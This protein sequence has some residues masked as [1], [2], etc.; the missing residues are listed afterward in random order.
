MFDPIEGCHLGLKELASEDRRGWSAAARADRVRGLARLAERTQAVLLRAVVDWDA[1]KDW[2]LDGQL[3]AASWLAWQTPMVKTQ[4]S[5]L[6]DDARFAGRHPDIADALSC[7]AIT[8]AHVTAMAR[9]ETHHE[10]EFAICKESLLES[11]RDMNPTD[12]AAVCRNWANLVD[13]RAPRDH[14]QR[15]FRVRELMD[16]WGVPD[17]LLDPETCALWKACMKDLNPPDT[18]DLPE[19]PRTANQRGADTLA[20]LCRRHLRGHTGNAPST[21]ADVVV[22]SDT[23]TRH[24]FAQFLLPADRAPHDPGWETCTIGGRPLG[25]RDAER[26][27]CDSPIGALIVDRDGEILDVGRQN[28]QYNRAQRRAM[29]RRDGP[30]CPWPGCDRPY[31]WLD[32]H[33][34]DFWEHGGHT[35][36]D[37]GAL[38]CRRH[39]ILIHTG[40]WTLQRDPDTGIYTATSPDGRTFTNDPRTKHHTRPPN[41]TTNARAPAHC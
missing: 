29:A 28:R 2:A 27:L 34:L 9:A 35:D 39:H 21:T 31:Q 18:A 26:L 17:G 32:G 41:T 12:F 23:L 13:D 8:A 30:T 40:G 25:L 5:R 16:G 3:G 15:G 19:G 14:A 38:V 20:D 4:G 37:R 36:L 22:D 7:G 1:G 6:V 10:T 24:R 11:A 33:H